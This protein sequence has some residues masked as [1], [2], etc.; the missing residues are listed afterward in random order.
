VPP[1]ALKQQG[2]DLQQLPG[3]HQP[4]QSVCVYVFRIHQ[5]RA[6]GTDL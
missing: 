3:R 6:G 1:K 2:A 4:Q 5:L